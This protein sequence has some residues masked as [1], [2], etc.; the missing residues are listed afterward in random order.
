M[1]VSKRIEREVHTHVTQVTTVLK[2]Q[3]GVFVGDSYQKLAGPNTMV[4]IPP[5]TS[6]EIVNE[7]G[8]DDVLKLITIYTKSAANES[9]D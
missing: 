6:H 8:G 5:N 7:G 2:G 9:W 1:G 3:G 4:V